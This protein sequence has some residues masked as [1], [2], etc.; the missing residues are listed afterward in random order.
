[1]HDRESWVAAG[2][3]T[4]AVSHGETVLLDRARGCYF[5]LSESGGVVWRLVR[6]DGGATIEE[7]VEVLEGEYEVERERVRA[8]VVAL[9]GRLRKGGLVKVAAPASAGAG[10][11]AA[12][13]SSRVA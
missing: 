12:L 6:R 9:V 7:M 4:S 11:G 1:M 13:V 5:V 3:V 2:S 10:S 8:D